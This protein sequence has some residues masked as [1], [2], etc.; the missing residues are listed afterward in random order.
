MLQLHLTVAY[1]VQV[2]VWPPA[3]PRIVSAVSTATSDTP[4]EHGQYDAATPGE[5]IYE[6]SAGQHRRTAQAHTSSSSK[7]DDA[8]CKH[9]AP[10]EHGAPLPPHSAPPPR[11]GHDPADRSA[12]PSRQHR[13]VELGDEASPEAAQ[14]HAV[15]LDTDSR[16]APP[17]ESGA[18]ISGIRP[19]SQVAD[20]ASDEGLP[21][22]N[23]ADGDKAGHSQSDQPQT[24]LS[25]DAA[26]SSASPAKHVGKLLICLLTVTAEP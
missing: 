7:P 12:A 3:A 2:E 1:L 17:C 18:A 23:S 16:H 26:S 8:Y 19:A 25:P 13:A 22:Q 21:V 14:Q 11:P 10:S 6:G 15:R 9:L 4:V 20:A 24:E 5:V